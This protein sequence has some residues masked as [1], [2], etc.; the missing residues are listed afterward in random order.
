MTSD[1]VYSDFVCT[2]IRTQ[3]TKELN[4]KFAKSMP[5][6][7]SLR[8][9]NIYLCNKS[10]VKE[11]V[12]RV[13]FLGAYSI[14]NHT[15]SFWFLGGLCTN[16]KSFIYPVF[17]LG[18]T[19]FEGLLYHMHHVYVSTLVYVLIYCTTCTFCLPFPDPTEVSLMVDGA[20]DQCSRGED[21]DFELVGFSVFGQVCK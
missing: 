16:Y 5:R 12:G 10:G 15:D 4:Q 1:R 14:Y 20:T 3:S 8:E 21:I 11:G 7:C 18:K 6:R 17:D 19:I 2:C 9:E 13:I